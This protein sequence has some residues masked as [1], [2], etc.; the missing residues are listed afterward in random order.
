MH[1]MVGI[2][3]PEARKDDPSL[4]GFAVAI[5]ILQKQDVVAVGHVNTPVTG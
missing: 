3:G 1:D 5:G 4:I 2:L